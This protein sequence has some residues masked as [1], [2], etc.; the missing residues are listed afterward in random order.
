ALRAPR[1][2]HRL[3]RWCLPLAPSARVLPFCVIP[4]GSVKKES[5]ERSIC[6]SQDT[7]SL[8]GLATPRP[9]S[10]RLAPAALASARPFAAVHVPGRLRSASLVGLRCLHTP[11]GCG[12]IFLDV[13]IFL[14][15]LDCEYPREISALSWPSGGQLRAHVT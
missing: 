5:S 9:S 3:R 6:G 1:T 7:V 11:L 13:D 12:Q 15:Q 14:V 8:A 2:H 10:R 4:D